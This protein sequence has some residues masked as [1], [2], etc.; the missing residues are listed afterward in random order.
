MLRGLFGD[1]NLGRAAES[2]DVLRAEYERGRAEAEGKEPPP[3]RIPHRE[4][5]PPT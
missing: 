3:K 1:K 5:P 2:L 4:T